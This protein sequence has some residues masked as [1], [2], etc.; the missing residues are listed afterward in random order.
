MQQDQRQFSEQ[1]VCS[2][3]AAACCKVGLPGEDGAGSLRSSCPS[4]AT[5]ALARMVA[6][7]PGFAAAAYLRLAHMAL[8]LR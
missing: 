4:D 2:A 7:G 8:P 3:R 6:G 1:L 5:S